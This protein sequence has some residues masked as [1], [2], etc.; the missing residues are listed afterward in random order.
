[1][2]GN[3]GLGLVSLRD[4][5][6]HE[7]IMVDRGLSKREF[8]CE[9][10]GECDTLMP[11]DGSREDRFNLNAMACGSSEMLRPRAGEAAMTSVRGCSIWSWDHPSGTVVFWTF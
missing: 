10:C 8:L 9:D 11:V 6:R 3:K 5:V 4:Y 1:M 2:G 7:I